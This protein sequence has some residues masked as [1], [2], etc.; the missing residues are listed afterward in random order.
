MDLVEFHNV[1]VRF[2]RQR[3]KNNSS[4]LGR[5]LA[6]ILARSHTEAFWALRELNF[7]I[8]EGD[9]LGIVGKNG[10]GKSTLLKLLA[11]VLYPDEGTIECKCRVSSLL[12]I[13]AGFMP[14]LSGRDNIYLNGAF[15]GLSK[16][17]MDDVFDEIVDF[18]ELQDF[19]DSPI[20]HYSSG[21]KTRL[22][23]SVAVHMKPEILI[24]DE[25][26]AAGDRGFRKKAEEKMRAFMNQARGI[27]LVSHNLS[28]VAEFCNKGIWLEN[29]QVRS[30]GSAS[31]II[32]AYK[33][34]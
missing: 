4:A 10:A 23:F 11:G 29:G 19:I 15:L 5:S 12:S 1:S 26:L 28:F 14:D 33:N 3:K 25:V 34:A 24:I 16:K 31:D 8:Q 7:S 20:R 18:S 27:V 30:Y 9:I 17:N 6:S 13:G 21:M 2:K 22:G 32:N